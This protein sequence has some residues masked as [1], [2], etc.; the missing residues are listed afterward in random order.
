V[1]VGAGSVVTVSG[2]QI[3]HNTAL[4]GG[5]I[6]AWTGG[7][8]IVS[9]S[10][11][12]SNTATNGDGG[13]IFVYFGGAATVSGTSI[14]NGTST[15]G[16]GGI[17]NA[18][19]L[20]VANSTMR[21]NAGLYGGIENVQTL[22]L[23]NSTLSGNQAMGAAYGGGAIDQHQI[24]SAP[25]ATILNCT[26]VSNTATI[27]DHSGIWLQAG[28]LNIGNSIVAH[29][30]VT[31]NVQVDDGTFT[32]LG[33]NLT[34]SGPGTPFTATTDLTDTNPR[35]G[36]LQA[37]G[38]STW[39]HAHPSESPATDRIPFGVNGCGTTVIVDQRGQPRPGT[40]TQR[41]DIG[42]YKVQGIY[43]RVYLPLV[44]K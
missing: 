5:G 7:R 26:I 2:V 8:A 27:T 25:S 31:N 3:S 6:Y 23:I 14:L 41:C 19:I 43:Y 9:G 36:P 13:G 24:G 44:L 34:N 40:F 10:Q 15:L 28:T 32:S 22:T 16:S 39:T 29:N 4:G 12:F 33:Y 18:G 20:T 11:L 35:L 30:G 17:T 38:G 37:N 21:G 42:A 1:Y